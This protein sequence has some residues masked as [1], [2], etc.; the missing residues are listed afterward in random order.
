MRSREQFYKNE[1]HNVEVKS[2]RKVH[3]IEEWDFISLSGMVWPV[4]LDVGAGDTMEYNPG[5]G[6]DY[7]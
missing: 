2:P 1:R 3:T 4:T 7:H 5:L 6:I